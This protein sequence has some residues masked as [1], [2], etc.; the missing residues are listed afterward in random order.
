MSKL[1]FLSNNLVIENNASFSMEVGTENNLFPLTNLPKKFTTKVFRSNENTCEIVIDLKQVS[2]LDTVAITGSAIDGMGVTTAAIQLSATPIFTGLPEITLDISNDFNIGFKSFTSQVARYVKVNLS[3]TGS[4]CELGNIFLGEADIIQN[5]SIS[6]SSF[7][8]S[9][10]DNSQ[11]VTNNYGQ[12]FTD[13][14]NHQTQL[15]GT[16]QYCNNEELKQIDDILL[17]HIDRTPVWIILDSTSNITDDGNFRFTGYY[18]L[19]RPP[20]WSASG[21][22]LFNISLQF[23]QVV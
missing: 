12:E 21:Y 10:M 23:K 17:R 8:Y 11:T 2:T 7:R 14:R 18:S 15:N 3:H 20:Q 19:Q 6:I 5:N 4:Y 16:I 22:G 1:Q 13:K 9:R